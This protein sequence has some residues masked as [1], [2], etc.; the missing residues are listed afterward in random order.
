MCYTNS[1][2]LNLTWL[3]V[4]LLLHLLQTFKTKLEQAFVNSSNSM[5]Q[6]S[7]STAQLQQLVY[8]N[9]VNPCND[10]LNLR[11]NCFIAWTVDSLMTPTPQ[12]LNGFFGEIFQQFE[13]NFKSPIIKMLLL[14]LPPWTPTALN[15][16]Y[17]LQTVQVMDND[18]K[19]PHGKKAAGFLFLLV[20]LHRAFITFTSLSQHNHMC[21][22]GWH[23]YPHILTYPCMRTRFPT[24]KGCMWMWFSARAAALPEGA[25]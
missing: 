5:S 12:W 1:F 10:P 14:L 20:K 21:T 6:W 16:H 25:R 24:H 11:I 13:K 9:L 18:D 22:L 3:L 17:C 2:Y 7:S 8:L 15:V 4:L 19:K 23:V